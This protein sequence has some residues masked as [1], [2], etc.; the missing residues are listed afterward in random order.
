M[1]KVIFKYK[2]KNKKYSEC[3]DIL[4]KEIIKILVKQIQ[5]KDTYFSY[6]TTMDLYYKSKKYLPEKDSK[7]AYEL[8]LL[9]TMEETEAYLLDEMMILYEKLQQK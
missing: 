7:I 4:R 9:D 2:L 8:Y 1:D 3:V 5:N 6:T